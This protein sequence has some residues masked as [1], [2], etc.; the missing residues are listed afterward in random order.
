M[1]DTTL[2]APVVISCVRDIVTKS[3]NSLLA[4]LVSM[5]MG[6]QA[7]EELSGALFKLK[8]PWSVLAKIPK[9]WNY[10][11]LEARRKDTQS[12]LTLGVMYLIQ[13]SHYKRKGCSP[14]LT[15]Y[16]SFSFQLPYP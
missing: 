12:T 14:K 4:H 2:T 1:P 10:T 16:T 5:V 9:E 7:T 6:W 3:T 11:P 15:A 8:I 13:E